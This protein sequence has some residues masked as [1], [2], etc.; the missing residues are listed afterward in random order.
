MA[1]CVDMRMDSVQAA[2]PHPT[3]DGGAADALGMQLS[4]TDDPVLPLREVAEPFSGRFRPDLGRNLPRFDHAVDR[5][6]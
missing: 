1:E 2:R 5:R 6:R 3:G 4:A